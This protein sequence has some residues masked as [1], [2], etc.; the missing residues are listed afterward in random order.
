MKR[1]NHTEKLERAEFMGRLEAEKN[2]WLFRIKQQA[3]EAI[4][5]IVYE[6]D[7]KIRNHSRKLEEQESNV[8]LV[9]KLLEQGELELAREYLEKLD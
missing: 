5:Q 7:R 6:S 8:W 4:D 9:R 2:Y 1:Q 3:D